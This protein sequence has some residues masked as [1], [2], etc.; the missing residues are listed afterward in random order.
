[1]EILAY[2]CLSSI[3]FVIGL[4]LIVVF[5]RSE[6]CWATVRRQILHYVGISA[7]VSL[8]GLL[9]FEVLAALIF[10]NRF[11]H[12]TSFSIPGDYLVRG[13]VGIVALIIPILAIIAPLAIAIWEIR[14]RSNT[15]V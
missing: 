3:F 2:L 9:L 5:L 12:P 6:A 8:T 15:S 13:V 11:G 10:S 1:M 14:K 7:G 4:A